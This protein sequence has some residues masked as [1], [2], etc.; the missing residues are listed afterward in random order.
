[1]PPSDPVLKN[2]AR[3][4]LASRGVV[5]VLLAL[6]AVQIAT[7]HGAT[8]ADE[9]GVFEAMA[10]QPFGRGLLLATAAGYGCLAFWEGFNATRKLWGTLRRVAAGS[11][12][13]LYL[14]LAG[15]ALT[16]V[17]SVHVTSEN[18]QVVDITG[19]VML[20][21]GGRLLVGAV[22]VGLIIAGA[23]L[24]RQGFVHAYGT[25]IDLSTASP[26]RRRLVEGVGAVGMSVRGLVVA[27]IG[28]FVLESAVTFD[29]G[30]AKGIDGALRT[31]VHQPLG[32]LWLGGVA[33]GLAAFG[34]FSLLE[35][36]YV[37]P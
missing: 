22:G 27:A 12:C 4:G 34:C 8:Q 24:V 35:I 36:P 10:R 16:V 2:L 19:R 1:M 31:L 3:F 29:P 28:Y 9:R 11:K 18:R 7:G 37:K 14:V 33:L 21:S 5:Y 15:S 23:V 30:H 6:V 26:G 32:P 20:H 25:E 17:L 13:L